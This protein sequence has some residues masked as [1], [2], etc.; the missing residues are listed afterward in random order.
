M[1]AQQ[2]GASLSL[3]ATEFSIDAKLTVFPVVGMHSAG[4]GVK[5]NFGQEPFRYQIKRPS[6]DNVTREWALVL[7]DIPVTKGTFTF[8]MRVVRC[9]EQDVECIY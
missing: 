1:H 3:T 7:P 9:L 8:E 5:V 4:A 6:Y 2:D